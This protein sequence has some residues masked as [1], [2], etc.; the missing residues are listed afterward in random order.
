LENYEDIFL[1]WVNSIVTK[2]DNYNQG[3]SGAVI[4]F[5]ENSNVNNCKFKEDFILRGGGRKL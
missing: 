1:E 2:L 3:D 4:L 5:I